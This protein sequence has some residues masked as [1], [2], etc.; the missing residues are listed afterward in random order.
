MGAREVRRVND[1]KEE[2]GEVREVS[3][4]GEGSE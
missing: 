3:V 1:R 2:V 4:E